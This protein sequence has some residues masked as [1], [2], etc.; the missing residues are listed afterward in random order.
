V[1]VVVVKLGAE[2]SFC[3]CREGMVR[4]GVRPSK[5]IDTTG[6]G[7]LYAAGFIFGHMHG[8]HPEI[9]GKIGAILAGRIIELIGAKM[10]ESNWE[11]LRREIQALMD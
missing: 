7:D 4:V 9:C 3:M 11:N 2:G 1:E 5:P 6:A 8:L 10:D